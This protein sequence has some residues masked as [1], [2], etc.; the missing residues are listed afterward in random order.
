MRESVVA[1]L[2]NS[3][4]QNTLRLLPR[5]L[6]FDP[7][8]VSSQSPGSLHPNEVQVQRRFLGQ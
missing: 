1:L 6:K 2:G 4:M 5:P 8:T 7:I 3:H